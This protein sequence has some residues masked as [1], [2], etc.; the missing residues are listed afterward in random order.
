MFQLIKSQPSDRHKDI[1]ELSFYKSAILL[2]MKAVF[3]QAYNL[4]L[5]Q[6]LNFATFSSFCEDFYSCH[7]YWTLI[8]CIFITIIHFIRSLA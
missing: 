1:S 6:M 8:F 7:F 4:S 5:M 2:S 3:Y